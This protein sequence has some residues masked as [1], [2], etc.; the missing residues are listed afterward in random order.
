LQNKNPVSK[1]SHHELAATR[2]QGLKGKITIFLADYLAGMAHAFDRRW[3]SVAQVLSFK[4]TR[5]GEVRR[6]WTREY[7]YGAGPDDALAAEPPLTGRLD[8][9]CGK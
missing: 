5:D 2:H 8:W 4:P 6:P 7:Q 3:L 1:G 9:D